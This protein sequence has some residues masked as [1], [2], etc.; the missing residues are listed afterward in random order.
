[1]PLFDY[2]CTACGAGFELLVRGTTVPACAGCGSTLLER[3]V[4]MPAPQGTTQSTLAAGRRA[5]AR[6]GHFSN[7]SRAERSR[8]K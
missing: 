4:S 3:Q 8:I 2:R 1:M 6:Q 7:Y 5:A